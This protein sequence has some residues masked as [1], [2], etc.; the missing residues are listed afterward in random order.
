MP[1]TA[2]HSPARPARSR[3]RPDPTADTFADNQG[4]DP[5]ATASAPDGSAPADTDAASA[6]PSP[7]TAD[8]SASPGPTTIQ[9]QVLAPQSDGDGSQ[10]GSQDGGD[11]GSDDGGVSG[12]ALP[13]LARFRTLEAGA[14][15]LVQTARRA[16]ARYPYE[17]PPNLVPVGWWPGFGPSDEAESTYRQLRADWE[18]F[19]RDGVGSTKLPHLRQ[20]VV[21]WRQFRDAWEA[22]SLPSNDLGGRL[23]AEVSRANRIRSELTG[24]TIAELGPEVRR[25][26][27]VVNATAFTRDVAA[28]VEQWAR[29]NPLVHALANPA[30]SPT[31]AVSR[32]VTA[33]AVACGASLV[34]GLLVARGLR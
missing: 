27:D 29:D 3:R 25:G 10:D 4:Q 17:A 6:S 1:R 14:A 33:A 34:I 18:A 20:D 28:P 23:N 12:A 13:P 32:M 22:G 16:G 30:L 31:T 5:N 2:T 8:P 7:A 11:D 15:A 9:V 21:E 19:E 26:V 24:K